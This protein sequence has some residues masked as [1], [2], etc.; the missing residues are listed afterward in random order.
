LPC[1]S[2]PRAGSTTRPSGST[3]SAPGSPTATL[4]NNDETD[5]HTLTAITGGDEGSIQ[6]DDFDPIE[7]A[8][9]GHVN[10]ADLAE[11]DKGITVTGD[12]DAGDFVTIKLDFD[13][14]ESVTM[15][16]PVMKPC[17]QLEGLDNTEEQPST[18]PLYSCVAGGESESPDEH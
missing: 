16:I 15:H 18:E 17:Y 1:P 2:S 14:D 13:N 8:P 10:L 9:G 11:A 12:F 5:S 4:S 7:I 6:A 3:P